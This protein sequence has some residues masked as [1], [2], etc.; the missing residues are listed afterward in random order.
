MIFFAFNENKSP[1]G[2]A[3]RLYD[4]YKKLMY[5]TAYDI[6]R[7]KSLAEDAVIESFEKIIK[8]LHK[9][10]EKNC[11]QTTSFMVIICRNTSIDIYNRQK[12]H[13]YY[14]EELTEEPTDD[15]Y[16]PEKNAVSKETYELAVKAIKELPD[17]YRDVFLMT[18]V[19][20]YTIEKTAEALGISVSAAKK[21]SERAK[22]AVIEKLKAQ[23]LL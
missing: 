10:D 18:R 2:K 15:Y 3:E 8:N 16:H 17:I 5:K 7:D 22:K 1:P 12:K 9:I 14:V 23:N 21:R 4:K 11:H 20:G 6:L 13:G 19:Y